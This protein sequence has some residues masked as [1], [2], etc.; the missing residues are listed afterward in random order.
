LSQATLVDPDSGVRQEVDFFGIGS[1]RMFGSLHLP[2]GAARGAVLVC[3]PFQSEFMAN[4]RR[5]VLL[6]RSLSARGIAVA[7]FHYRGTGHSDGD[8]AD[9]T[10]ETMRRDAIEATGWLREH[11]DVEHLGF[12]G[13]RWGA[14]VAASLAAEYGRAPLVVW[15][16]AVDGRA[17]FREIFRLRAMSR[18]SRGVDPAKSDA[19]EEMRVAGYADMGGF[20][21]YQAM[22]DSAE[23][24]TLS[25]LLGVAPRA[26][27]L[28]QVDP[29][30]DLKAAYR[31]V[32]D[33]WERSDLEVSVHLIEGLEAWWFSG[34]R[35]FDSSL[36]QSKAMVEV[37]TDW[38]AEHPWSV[39]HDA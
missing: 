36:P 7:R 26:V 23:G 38:F 22:F 21:L 30:T 33:L 34:T 1:A 20:A 28:V 13:T 6:A 39:S 31:S 37:T 27:L 16:P 25:G 11:V 17:Y 10:F 18:L 4:Y 29:R 5:E 19:V 8:A 2:A 32:V 9:V 24:R 12:L 15:D 35:R 14:L 3:S